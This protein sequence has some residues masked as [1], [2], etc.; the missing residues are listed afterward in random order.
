MRNFFWLVPNEVLEVSIPKK[1]IWGRKIIRPMFLYWGP[2]ITINY[3]QIY[4]YKF[5]VNITE[6]VTTIVPVSH[7]FPNIYVITKCSLS[8]FWNGAVAPLLMGTRAKIDIYWFAFNLD[9]TSVRFRILFIGKAI[10]I[11]NSKFDY[12]I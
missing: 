4:S 10:E 8:V 7:F 1:V 9:S 12:S 3:A 5:T 11:L 2:K 6:R